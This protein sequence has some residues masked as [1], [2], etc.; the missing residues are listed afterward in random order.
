MT[1]FRSKIAVILVDSDLNDDDIRNRDLADDESNTDPMDCMIVDRPPK[2]PKSSNSSSEVELISQS[3]LLSPSVN[4]T[5]DD[6][7]DELCLYIS[8]VD[9]VA[10]LE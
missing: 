4:V 3:F 6:L 8:M 1:H 5:H 2:K 9:D 10:S 7:I